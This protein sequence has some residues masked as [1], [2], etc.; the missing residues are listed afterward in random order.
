MV[1]KNVPEKGD[2]T[3]Y[4]AIQASG[5][6]DVYF[7]HEEKVLN[8]LIFFLCYIFLNKTA[9]RYGLGTLLMGENYFIH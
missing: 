4:R 9:P 3:Q 5:L 1:Q 7:C 6:Q 2:I 8:I